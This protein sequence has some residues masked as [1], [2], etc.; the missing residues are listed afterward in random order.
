LSEK[1]G[2]DK[3]HLEIQVIGGTVQNVGEELELPELEVCIGT[4]L[5]QKVE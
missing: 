1:V 5:P 4:F 3:L 2:K